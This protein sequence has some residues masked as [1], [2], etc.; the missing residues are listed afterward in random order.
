[1]P[2]ATPSPSQLSP[3]RVQQMFAELPAPQR[4]VLLLKFK[5][6][7][8]FAQIS[9]ATGQ[10]PSTVCYLAHHGLKNLAA[11]LDIK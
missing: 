7:W 8:G 5:R 3:E 1:M 4:E 6:G 11:K 2:D 10:P 9:E